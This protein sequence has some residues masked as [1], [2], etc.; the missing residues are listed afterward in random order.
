MGLE[1]HHDCAYF[2]LLVPGG[3]N[4]G[5]TLF[6]DTPYLG[7]TV[8]PAIDDVQ[9]FISELLYDTF[10]HLRTDSLDQA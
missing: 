9:R 2:L 4:H 10:R 3:G 7:Q 1:K 8:N 6:T 5:N